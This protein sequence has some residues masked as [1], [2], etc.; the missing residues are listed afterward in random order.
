MDKPC[1]A[2]VGTPRKSL[3]EEI[4]T[5]ITSVG[6]VKYQWKDANRTYFNPD[7]CDLFFFN[8]INDNIKRISFIEMSLEDDKLSFSTD[9]L[10]FETL[11]DL[12]KRCQLG[13]HILLAKPYEFNVIKYDNIYEDKISKLFGIS[14]IKN[15]C[16]E[17]VKKDYVNTLGFN[18][19]KFNNLISYFNEKILRD[20]KY[21]DYKKM[22]IKNFKKE[23]EN[24]IK[25][26]SLDVLYYEGDIEDEKFF[27]IAKFYGNIDY[28]PNILKEDYKEI[29]G[30]Y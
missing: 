11:T 19:S 3:I 14:N 5:T 10:G 25:I 26:N 12:S 13:N 1:L 18:I 9:I 2:T 27:Y 24:F 20:E 15:I 29:C 21:I 28:L 7:E 22:Y 8:G 17:N 6:E 30:G 4:P 23:I 16:L